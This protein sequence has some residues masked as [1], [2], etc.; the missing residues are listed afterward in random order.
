MSY[1]RETV[2][3]ALRKAGQVLSDIDRAYAGKI[4]EGIDAQRQPFRGIT[5]TVPVEDV[6]DGIKNGSADSQ[7]EAVLGAVMDAG[8]LGANVASRYALPAGGITLAGKALYDLTTQFG[9][10]ADQP[11]PT[12]LHM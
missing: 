5:T 2:G 6:I 10:M 4:A 8:V 1:G 9:G 3:N 12:T 11:E 7:M